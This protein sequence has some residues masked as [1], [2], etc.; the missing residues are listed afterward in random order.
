M[1]CGCADIENDKIIIAEIEKR[2]QM[3]VLNKSIPQYKT[4]SIEGELRQLLYL[5]ENENVIQSIVRQSDGLWDVVLFDT[6]ETNHF[7]SSLKV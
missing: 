6:P 3:N 5:F 1:G 2:K 4:I 7:P